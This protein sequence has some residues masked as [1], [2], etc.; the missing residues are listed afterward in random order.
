VDDKLAG[1][2]VTIA[3][4]VKAVGL[5]GE[6]KL[7]PLIDWYEPLLGSD[8]LRWND[9]AVVEVDS[10]RHSR[11]CY[12]V[13]TAGLDDRDAADNARGRSVG[14]LRSQYTE[15]AF[16]KPPGGLPFRYVGRPVCTVTGDEIGTV[17][18]VRRHGAQYTLVIQGEEGEV[19]IPAVA[20][21]L[22]SEDG[23][24]GPL[25]IDPPKGLL[26]VAGH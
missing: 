26:D 18:E 3:E 23:L 12:V 17:D 6:I 19:L 1:D 4:V 22:R 8:Y 11:D 7:Y 24:D 14:F 10:W 16:P 21:I 20:P 13:K 25:T 2:F 9:G 5:R 15:P